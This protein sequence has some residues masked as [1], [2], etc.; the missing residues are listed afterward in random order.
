M[1]ITI[2]KLNGHALVTFFRDGT[3]VHTEIFS[4]K[5]DGPYTRTIKFDGEYDSHSATA[6]IGLLDF[7]YEV[8]P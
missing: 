7:T 2:S 4:G 1:K 8:V 3:S 6:V 5:T